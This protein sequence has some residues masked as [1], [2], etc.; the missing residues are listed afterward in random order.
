MKHTQIISLVCFLALPFLLLAQENAENP[1]AYFNDLVKTLN[2]S[3]VNAA[4]VNSGVKSVDS[5]GSTPIAANIANG[6]K[7]KSTNNG[8]RLEKENKLFKPY[9]EVPTPNTR[10]QKI[11]VKKLENKEINKMRLITLDKADIVHSRTNRSLRNALESPANLGLRSEY[12]NSLSVIPLNNINIDLKTSIKPFVFI[13]DYLTTGELITPEREDTLLS[14]LGE[15][16]LEL[17]IDISIPTV[18]GVKF[19]LLKGSLAANTGLFVQERL[20]I[21]T[22]FFSIIF[23]GT[24]IEE[25]FHM[26][27]DLGVNLNAYM[28]TSLA[29][30]SF[31]ELP[32]IFGELR[33]GAA[34]NA[35]AGAFSSVNISNLALIPSE[36]NAQVEGTIETISFMD[37][38]N[39]IAPGGGFNFDYSLADDYVGIPKI[40]LGYDVGFAWR[41][42]LNRIIPLLPNILKNYVDVQVGLQDL[43][44]KI[45]MNHAYF[46]E[47]NFSAE[48]VDLLEVF[49]GNNVDLSSLMLVEETMVHEDTSFSKPLGA[50]FN[51]AIN[52]QPISLI[53]LKGSYS[54]YISDGINTVLGKSYS[55]GAEIYPFKSL[56]LHGSVFQKGQYRYSELGFRFQGLSGELGLTVRLYDLDFS[57]TE[58][59]QGAGL[60]LYWAQY[61]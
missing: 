41:F 14:S 10:K 9:I 29:Y 45:T 37:T 51:V 49:S 16:G 19:N 18:L 58:N 54:T 21:P 35:Y 3:E 34:V 30:G 55:Y 17:P 24:T 46:R 7:A 5:A 32:S 52:Y 25:P 61:F 57:F 42:K 40:T 59:I 60:K 20:R 39:F 36:T 26:T 22:E 27:E 53:M 56:A 48:A 38:L 47:I 6:K 28:K 31:F 44:A 43:G 1:E 33:F 23:D 12:T 15:N 13:E 50:K 4:D 8:E 11:Y 2:T